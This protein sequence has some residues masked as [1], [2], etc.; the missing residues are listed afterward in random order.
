MSRHEELMCLFIQ[1][2]VCYF[3]S[4][5]NYR[6]L[7]LAMS[8]RKISLLSQKCRPSRCNRRQNEKSR[9]TIEACLKLSFLLLS[10][11]GL[12]DN[13]DETLYIGAILRTQ[14][15][16]VPAAG[17]ANPILMQHPCGGVL[18]SMKTNISGLAFPSTRENPAPDGM[19]RSFRQVCL[20]VMIPRGLSHS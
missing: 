7:F 16:A 10:Q 13:R 20:V 19:L 12:S 5:R 18:F 8:R 2:K 4:D 17:V 14:F 15:S 6:S 9:S 3:V 1:S 11:Q